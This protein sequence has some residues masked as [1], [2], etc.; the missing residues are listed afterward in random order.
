MWG[1]VAEAGAAHWICVARRATQ[2]PFGIEA[3]GRALNSD[4]ELDRFLAGVERRA[5]RMAE[6]AIGDRDQA[7][8]LVQDAMMRLAG[9]YADRPAAQWP[10]LFHRIL[11]NRIRDWRRRERL[12]RRLHA[13]WDGSPG[14]DPDEAQGDPMDCLPDPR[15]ATPLKEITRAGAIAALGPIIRG[16]P[17]ASAPRGG[18]ME[19]PHSCTARAGPRAVPALARVEPRAACTDPPAL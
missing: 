6:F 9:R 18:A 11:Q 10:P 8:D 5:L 1:A 12:R 13:W 16:A 7:L 15:E 17:T 2:V 19:S 14:G 4:G 3:G